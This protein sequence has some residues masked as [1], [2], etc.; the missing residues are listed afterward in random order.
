V[1]NED[2]TTVD[3]LLEE[4]RTRLR[5]MEPEAALEAQRQ[6]ALLIDSRSES[7]QAR[8]GLIPAAT[9]VQRNVLEWRLD[10][11]CPHRDPVL[12]KRD[13]LV[14]LVCNQGYQSTLAAANLRKFGIDA[15]D[16][17]G[18]AQ[19]WLAAGL[20]TVPAGSATA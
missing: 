5:G 13:R 11:A 18:G 2:T 9:V 8:D 4:A 1:G 16:V 17:I 6:G 15:T 12:A 3:V 20:P 7:Q 19:A 10:P 14:I